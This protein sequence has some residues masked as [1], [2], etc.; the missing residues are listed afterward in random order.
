MLSTITNMSRRVHPTSKA[1][2]CH[3][4]QKAG[5]SSQIVGSH[6]FRDPKGRVVCPVFLKKLKNNK[7]GLCDHT[8]HFT[9]KC[10]N[11][12]AKQTNALLEANEKPVNKSTVKPVATNQWDVFGQDSS[13]DEDFAKVAPNVTMRKKANV[14]KR[15]WADYSDDEEDEVWTDAP[16]A[17]K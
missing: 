15:S 2:G 4:C 7:C 17:K 13:D 1:T 11:T 8:G 12:N 14:S 6:N 16:W 9:D 3:I 5:E 10:P